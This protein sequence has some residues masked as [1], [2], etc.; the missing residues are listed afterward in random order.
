M[1]NTII[2]SNSNSALVS[3]LLESENA[4]VNPFVYAEKNIVPPHSVQMV[5]I[6]PLNTANIV[7]SG[8][9]D[10]DVPKQGIVRRMLL[11]LVITKV[12]NSDIRSK[13]NHLNAFESVEL[14]SSGRRISLLTREGMMA[15]ISDMPYTQRQA[16]INALNMGA[17]SM[18]GAN[19]AADRI[20]FPLDFFFNDGN[21]HALVTNFLEPLRVR[22][23]LSPLNYHIDKDSTGSANDGALKPPTISQ[24]N[25]LIEYR[26]LPNVFTDKLIEQNYGDGMLTQLI[27]Q[28]S[29]ETPKTF[30][31]TSTNTEHQK[32]EVEL[33]E[34]SAV[35]AL[36]VVCEV[37][38][39]GQQAASPT[40]TIQA[41][42]DIPLPLK[43][44]KLEAGGQTIMDVPGEYLQFWG[45]TDD[46]R[47]KYYSSGL[48]TGA[49]SGTDDH[50][51]HFVYKI[52]F[53]MGKED[54]SNV[55]SFRELSSKKLTL[56]LL[57]ELNDTS[58]HGRGF[59]G[60]Q[61][62]TGTVQVIYE[63]AQLMT[64][65]SSTGRVNLSLNN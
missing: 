14:L 21:R 54:T 1:S 8:T 53:G 45:R 40:D 48:Q 46:S 15:K 65:Q 32:V 44:V 57:R 7:A 50:N 62:K 9:L 6:P 10:Y 51:L 43:S 56:H 18:T 25:L 28:F 41:G 19:I 13:T 5:S 26:E 37:R 61:G 39:E 29:Y 23:R 52:D 55:V 3:T 35:K 60:L 47:N 2:N 49:G 22:V 20:V 63:T 11:D 33:K 64:T 24:A 59:A 36:Y 58:G 16:Y 42:M 4:V 27:N 30:T 38:S 34:T 12:V 17:A 31:V